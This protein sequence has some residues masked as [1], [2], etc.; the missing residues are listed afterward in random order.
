MEACVEIAT[1]LSYSGLPGS[2]HDSGNGA[3]L[4]TD[5]FDHRHG[6]LADSLDGQGRKDK[7]DHAADKQAGQYLGLVDIDS[8]NTGDANKSGEKGEG[9]QTRRKRSQSL[10]PSQRWCF[11][12]HQGYPFVRALPWAV[13]S[14]RRSRRRYRQWDQRRQW[15]SCMAVV[16][17]MPAAAIATPYRPAQAKDPQIPPARTRIGRKGGLHAHG[18]APDD[19][20]RVTGPGLTDDAQ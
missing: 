13:R 15:P 5:F 6:G 8:L 19:I 11:L 18:E 1:H 16:A 12:R 3:E 7:G 4:T 20:G 2:F 14:F 9:G 10:Y 17:I